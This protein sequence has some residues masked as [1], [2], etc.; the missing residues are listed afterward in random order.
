MADAPKLEVW[1]RGP[2]PNITALLQ[3]I[4]HALLQ[5]QEEVHAMMVDFPENLLWERPFNVASPAFHLQHLTGVLDRLFT[6]A[7]GESLSTIQ[8]GALAAEGRF[9]E[10][11]TVKELVFAL[12]RQVEQSVSELAQTNESILTQAREVG[13][14]KLPSTVIGLLT[15]SA[16][17]TTRH[18]GQLL[19]TVK[20]LTK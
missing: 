11:I 15:H 2:L 10:A 14:A 13:R 8:L 19:V 7:R 1:L 4:A 17:H 16:E 9:N 5:A 3:P 6:Y 12:D 18:V 20:I